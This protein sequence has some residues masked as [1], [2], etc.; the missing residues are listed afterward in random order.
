MRVLLFAVGLL[1]IS[2]L[3][4]SALL[5]EA[6]KSRISISPKATYSDA[7]ECYQYYSVAEEVARKFE[8][9]PKFTADQA[10]GFQLQAILAKQVLASWSGH[11]EG[12][13]GKRT[14]AQIDADLKKLGEPVVADAN[15]ALEGDKAAAGRNGERGKKCS[16]FET[17]APA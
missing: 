12:V 9:S 13:K 15:A 5:A 11:L 4:L 14:K 1:V 3:S 17:V 2:T 7:V 10:A 8:K 6:Q 16:G